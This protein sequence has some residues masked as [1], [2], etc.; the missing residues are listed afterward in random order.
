MQGG[1]AA[2]ARF[3]GVDGPRWFVRALLTGPAAQ[4]LYGAEKSGLAVN[5]GKLF[6]DQGLPADAAER[7]AG[8]VL[9][10]RDG[11]PS[12]DVFP[13]DQFCLQT[14]EGRIA[15]LRIGEGADKEDELAVQVTVWDGVA[16]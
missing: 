12:L 4:D 13:G 9:A 3:L 16:G 7:C 14:S 11:Y 1:G 10:A 2:P 5:D 6:I 8:R 15:W